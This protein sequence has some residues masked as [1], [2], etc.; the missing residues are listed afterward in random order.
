MAKGEANG[1]KRKRRKNTNY[2][3]I[4]IIIIIPRHTKSIFRLAVYNNKID[5]QSCRLI[6]GICL[7]LE[8]EFVLL[9]ATAREIPNDFS[10]EFFNLLLLGMFSLYSFITWAFVVYD[11]PIFLFLKL[12][13]SV[14]LCTV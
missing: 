3:I 14:C 5:E 10:L 7:Y 8:T 1:Q 13:L 12:C 4:M 2:I 9:T 6:W 11:F